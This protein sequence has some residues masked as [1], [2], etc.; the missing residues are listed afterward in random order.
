MCQ[1][2]R[3]WAAG[4]A[5]QQVPAG[6]AAEIYGLPKLHGD[7]GTARGTRQWNRRHVSAKRFCRQFAIQFWHIKKPL[8]ALRD[9]WRRS[10]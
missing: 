10:N 6:S 9:T 8:I 3:S 5:A 7:T 2:L 1:S 4:S